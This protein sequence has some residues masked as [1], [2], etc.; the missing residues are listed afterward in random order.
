[1]PHLLI[2]EI[3]AA[4]NAHDEERLAALY[5]PEFEEVDV[6]Q[7]ISQPGQNAIRTTMRRY[8][9]A[10]PDLQISMDEGVG[11]GDKLALAWTIR[12]T[13]QGKLMNIPPTGRKVAFR[14][15]SFLTLKD[16]KIARVLRVWD[17]AGLLRALGL[18]PEL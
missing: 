9:E 11:E 8:L 1:M 15:T 17:L 16:G 18:L 4:W 12:G 3:T 7:A 2:A 6:G 13:H 5:H 10:F 14:G